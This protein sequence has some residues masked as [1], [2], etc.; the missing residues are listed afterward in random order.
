MKA[1]CLKPEN[2]AYKYYGGR[3]I[4]LSIEWY[5]FENFYRD[6]GECPAHHSIERLDVNGNYTKENCIW[7]DRRLQNR[8][9]RTTRYLEF[10]GERKSMAEFAED[11][12]IPYYVLNA[13]LNYSKWSLEMALLT[14]VRTSRK[15][16]AKRVNC[17]LQS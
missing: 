17:L 14:P 7:L 1:R 5:R 11:Y 13:R 2:A 15:H 4:D 8:N 9:K 3:G 10:K 16:N 6:M 12:N